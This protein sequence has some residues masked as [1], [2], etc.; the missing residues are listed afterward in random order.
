ML[1]PV[2][3]HIRQY[4]ASLDYTAD[5]E[6]LRRT[7]GAA[8]PETSLLTLRVCTLMLQLGEGEGHLLHLPC[9]VLL[10]VFGL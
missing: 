7:I 10:Y 9:P 3:E 6:L 5:V 1:G 8:I 4:V 2:P